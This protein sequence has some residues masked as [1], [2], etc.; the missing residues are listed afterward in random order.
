MEYGIFT[1]SAQRFLL[2]VKR[3]DDNE[4]VLDGCGGDEYTYRSDAQKSE[5]FVFHNVQ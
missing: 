5:F 3:Y 2:P 4:I 1:S